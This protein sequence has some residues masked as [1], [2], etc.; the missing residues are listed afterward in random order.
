ME[1][2]KESSY[3]DPYT[4]TGLYSGLEYGA[5]GV[6]K[7][8]VNAAVMKQYVLGKLNKES[9]S[10]LIIGSGN[11]Y[12]TAYLRELGYRCVNLEHYIPDINIVKECSVKASADA[13]PF[14]DK[15]FSIAF[16]CE[17][18]EHIPDDICMGILE[19]VKR[20]SHLY[21]FTVAT[22]GDGHF[23]GHINVHDGE[24]WISV[25]RGIF[26]GILHAQVNPSVQ[27]IHDGKMEGYAY[28]DGVMIY[29][30]C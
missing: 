26:S 16:C 3:K 18:L 11:G 19:E 14:R 20:V 17:T 4:E 9:V 15:S 23:G 28:P 22:R 2:T 10:I 25:F 7:G 21:Y 29:G 27:I 1:E 5:P 24:W 8:L 30:T 13:M 6:Q 12:E